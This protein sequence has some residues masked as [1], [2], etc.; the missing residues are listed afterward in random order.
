ML[1]HVLVIVTIKQGAR[2]AATAHFLNLLLVK[3][4]VH[5]H[6]LVNRQLFLL[7]IVDADVLVVVQ[8]ILLAVILLHV[9]HQVLALDLVFR[10]V[11][12]VVVVNIFLDILFPDIASVQ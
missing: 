10:I 12:V 4:L 2:S 7:I 3:V 6:S 8:L 1:V 5:H 11:K 9:L